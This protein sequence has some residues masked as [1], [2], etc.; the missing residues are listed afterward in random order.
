[1]HVI[2][3]VKII[4]ISKIRFGYGTSCHI[5]RHGAIVIYTQNNN[6]NVSSLMCITKKQTV[7]VKEYEN[8]LTLFGS[9]DAIVIDKLNACPKSITY[10]TNI[11]VNHC[12]NTIRSLPTMW[13]PRVGN[14]IGMVVNCSIVCEWQ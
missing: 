10:D 14:N 8:G 7:I 5:D 1:M 2:R 12:I 6:V 3:H 11:Y 4:K 13:K 9:F